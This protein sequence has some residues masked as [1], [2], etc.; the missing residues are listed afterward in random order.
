MPTKRDE[1]ATVE[2]GARKFRHKKRIMHDDDRSFDARH[3]YDVKEVVA[4][5]DNSSTIC[6]EFLANL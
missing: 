1:C 2:E 6:C 5:G 3:I 4:H